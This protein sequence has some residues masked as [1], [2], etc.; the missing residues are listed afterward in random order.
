[1]DLLRLAKASHEAVGAR[2]LAVFHRVADIIQALP[3]LRVAFPKDSRPHWL[4]RTY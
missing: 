1:M 2:A 4:S 3:G